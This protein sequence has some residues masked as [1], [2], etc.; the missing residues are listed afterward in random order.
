[1]HRSGVA[2]S[3]RWSS[4]KLSSVTPNIAFLRSPSRDAPDFA[5]LVLDTEEGTRMSFASQPDQPIFALPDSLFPVRSRR[6]GEEPDG[7]C[8]AGSDPASEEMRASEQGEVLVL[9]NAFEL[10]R[11]ARAFVSALA[12]IKE[13]VGYARLV[14]APGM[15][16]LSNLAVLAYLGVDIF[17]SSLLTYRSL[18]GEASTAEG[19]I[20]AED[21]PWLFGSGGRD[22]LRRNLAAAWQEL[23]LVRH[24]IK[25]GRLREL[26]EVRSQATPWGVAALRL[27]DLEHQ[28]LQDR[29]TPIIGPRFYAN[30]KQSLLRPDVWRWRR[31]VME[32]WTPAPHK[33][34]LLLIPCSARKPYYLS[35]SHQLFREVLMGLPNPGVVQELI[36]TSPLGVVPRELELFY[37][38]AQYDIPVTG[39][40]D[41]EEV[42]MVQQLVSHAVSQGFE[43]VV[44]HLGAESEFVRQ[45]APGAVDTSG[46]SVTS[47]DS[48][49]RLREE[50]SDACSPFPNVPRA[51]ERT[52]A[53]A[54]VARF[55]FGAGGD[56]LTEGCGI[57][58]N[59]PYSKI[60]DGRVQMGMLTPER[61]MISLTMEG[62]ARLLPGRK[63]WVEMED[64]DLAGNLFAVG[65]RDADP[66]LRVG[67]EA[68]ILRSGELEGVGIAAMCGE[69]MAASKRGEAVRVRHKRHSAKA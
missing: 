64:F 56:A 28:G 40:W 53:M 2:H 43:K 24:M 5:E 36:V 4:G 69:E 37:P 47:G 27:F 32:R 42:A 34:V 16:D 49:R 11:D 54:A 52:G 6:K 57:V 1:M 45:V 33:K 44:C 41:L 31:R 46:G 55:Q 29:Y 58:G 50:L 7:G 15:M 59:Y 25:A 26:A 66:G 51:V 19:V 20:K 17:D 62:A 30:S 8:F 18:N 10:R 39:H 67:D 65:I 38:A 68:I 9:E 23:Q 3:A 61:G 63:H 60:M 13:K 48:L 14:Y 22:L 12:S 21:A 35:R